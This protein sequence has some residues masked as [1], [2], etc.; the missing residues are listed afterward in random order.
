MKAS[1]YSRMG[2]LVGS[3]SSVIITLALL[4]PC[5][6]VIKQEQW[7]RTFGDYEWDVGFFVQ[8]TSDGGYIVAGYTRG[9]GA[10]GNDVWLIKT[11]SAGEKQWDRTFGGPDWDGAYCVQQTS[12]GGYIVAGYTRI[13]GI[14]DVWLIKT[15]STGTKQW[16]R[17]FGNPDWDGAYCVQ[18]TSDDGYII[19]GWRSWQGVGRNDV[20]LIKTDSAGNKQWDKTF[21]DMGN[22]IGR[23]VQQTSDGGYIVAGRT[24]SFGAGNYDVWLIKTDCEG[25]KKWDSAF[26]GPKWDVGSCVQQTSDSGYIIVGRTTSFGAGAGDVWLIK[27]D[28]VGNK[29]WDKTFGGSGYDEGYSVK[30]TSDG[31]FI[32]AG[33]TRSYQDGRGDVWLIKTDFVG[34]KQWDKTFGGSGYDVSYCVQQTSDSGYILTGWTRSYGNDDLW[35]IK[36]GVDPTKSAVGG[37]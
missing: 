3:L 10:G 26:G 34:N 36:V 21:G 32:I 31:G 6:S 5:C 25:N 17:I 30:Q 23:Y 2:F 35:L 28:S 22:D 1:K 13:Q 11:D 15:D 27:T 20:W 14:D 29:Q 33:E 19:T 37:H 7:D 8:Q 24:S 18:Q 12:D 9:Y 4:M 16:D